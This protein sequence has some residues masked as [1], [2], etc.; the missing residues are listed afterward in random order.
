MLQNFTL[1]VCIRRTGLLLLLFHSQ[2]FEFLLSHVRLDFRC[3][4]QLQEGAVGW[5]WGRGII[6][7]TESVAA[8]LFMCAIV[9]RI[10]NGAAF[11]I[12]KWCV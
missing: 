4:W 2:L 10:G 7:D 8:M 5:R 11:A 12:V 3:K 1:N 6:S 9:L